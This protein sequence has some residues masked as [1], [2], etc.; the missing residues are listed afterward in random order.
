M[1]GERTGRQKKWSHSQSPITFSVKNGY[2][3]KDQMDWKGKQLLVG[4]DAIS[5]RKVSEFSST[6]PESKNKDDVW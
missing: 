2:Y 1:R 6:Y 4:F 5:R 3:K